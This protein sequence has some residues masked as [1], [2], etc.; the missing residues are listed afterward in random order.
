MFV[1]SV[2]AS[3]SG[4]ALSL[5]VVL[6]TRE[7]AASMCSLILALGGSRQL[8]TNVQSLGFDDCRGAEDKS[9]KNVSLQGISR[10]STLTDENA[11][12]LMWYG[13]YSVSV[14]NSGQ[15]DSSLLC[16]GD[17]QTSTAL[18]TLEDS[19]LHII[20]GAMRRVHNHDGLSPV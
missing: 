11:Y 12:V 19:G 3:R 8:V 13:W 18:L 2:F 6:C 9:I 4:I 14:G 20:N 7:T 16:S 1:R 17:M 15:T 5:P 10:H